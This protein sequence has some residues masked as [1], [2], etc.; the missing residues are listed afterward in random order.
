MVLQLDLDLLP[1]ASLR[2]LVGEWMGLLAEMQKEIT[3]TPLVA[4]AQRPMGK[5]VPLSENHFKSLIGPLLPPAVPKADEALVEIAVDQSPP[6]DAGKH[7]MD[8]ENRKAL[9]SENFRELIGPLLPPAP[10]VP[11]DDEALVE[12]QGNMCLTKLEVKP[13]KKAAN[14]KQSKVGIYWAETEGDV[15]GVC[16]CVVSLSWFLCGYRCL[17]SSA[18]A[19]LGAEQWTSGST[20]LAP[21]HHSINIH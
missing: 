6:V 20:Q 16:H 2:S 5:K 4:S 1:K 17:G 8:H 18:S 15:W 12:E 19:A 9:L 13:L 7:P 3:Q 14:K 21:R 10:S 11:K